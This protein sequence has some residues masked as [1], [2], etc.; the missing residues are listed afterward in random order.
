MFDDKFV[1]SSLDNSKFERVTRFE[2]T[3]GVWSAEITLDV[4]CELFP[5]KVGE[6]VN[7][8]FAEETET[9]GTLSLAAMIE[10]Y[11][12][13]M[14]GRIFRSEDKPGDRRVVYASFGG[15]LMAFKADKDLLSEFGLDKRIHCLVRKTT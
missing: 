4:H 13:V 15:L 1:V 7:I 3:S 6:K 9:G 14:V 5:V 8:M 2:A 11:D 10:E 12:Y